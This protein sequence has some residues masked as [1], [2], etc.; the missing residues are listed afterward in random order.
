MTPGR[1]AVA[2]VLAG[3]AAARTAWPL[4]DTD[5]YWHLA[6]GRAVV[7]AGSRTF[8]EPFALPGL[9]APSVVAQEWLWDVG[10]YL[11]Q[12]AAGPVAIQLA[13]A[14]TA[15]AMALAVARL[16][17]RQA[18]VF[19][20]GRSAAGPS[21]AGFVPWLVVT[22]LVVD[23]VLHRMTPR[24]E[25]LLLVG[26]PLAFTALIDAGRVGSPSGSPAGSA[27][28]PG[29]WLR[30]FGVPVLITLVTMQVHPL[31][32]LIV[33]GAPFFVST[34]RWRTDRQGVLL[35]GLALAVSTLTG[36]FGAG[37]LANLLAHI[38]GDAA[39]H[40]N[41]MRPLRWDDLNPAS[42]HAPLVFALA[43]ALAAMGV[44]VGL[45]RRPPAATLALGLAAVGLA[46]VARRGVAPAAIFAVPMFVAG[47]GA[48]AGRAPWLALAAVIGVQVHG[49]AI[50]RLGNGSWGT[51][52]WEPG[53]VPTAAARYLLAQ[54]SAR[55]LTGYQAGGALGWLGDGHIRTWVDGRTPLVFDALAFARAR[56]AAM[57]PGA[58][59]HEADR[60]DASWAVA[61]SDSTLCVTLGRAGW[62][63]VLV[64]PGWTTFS[65]A[66]D[67]L[68]L[69]ALPVCEMD[70]V[71]DGAC[72]VA[73]AE[74]VR[75]LPWLD[76]AGAGV[77]GA[78]VDHACGRW[79]TLNALA[80]ESPVPAD[81]AVW[82]L[83]RADAAAQTADAH[84]ARALLGPLVRA[85][86]ARAIS[87]AL[88]LYRLPDGA[89]DA[90]AALSPLADDVDT[91]L[92]PVARLT[93][94]EAC[95]R[96]GDLACAR[97][98]G[99]RAAA[100]LPQEAAPLLAWLADQGRAR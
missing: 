41:D 44:A 37:W 63:P 29:P 84:T 50:D 89:D 23:L 69:V 74:L 71:A 15:A 91:D 34:E 35:A 33:A 18:A 19:A 90:I 8:P 54:G 68:A 79:D 45:K 38:G 73:G 32:V 72:E 9:S 83:V 40:I 6:Y 3:V 81:A 39:R 99:V 27:V 62:R 21:G 28:G 78:L 4:L 17:D 57:D 95:A 64:E 100:R 98:H 30:S 12:Q 24:P 87:R 76:D 88:P 85:G 66:P 42:G 25:S 59:A 1:W 55:V 48:V 70:L 20:A 67:A 11:L 26:M 16:V 65:R 86:D 92:S 53:S 97:F 5:V 80:T 94:A 60:L 2:G 49:V 77:Y 31:G 14:A 75:I 10:A 36:P 56:D 58:L 93:L 82:A 13:L 51:A 52:G 46:L 61:G 47:L 43:F 96:T 22:M 7:R